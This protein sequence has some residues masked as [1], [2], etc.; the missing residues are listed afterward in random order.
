[1]VLSQMMGLKV[2]IKVFSVLSAEAF[3]LLVVR[4]EPQWH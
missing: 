4:I 2:G 3:G 1:M